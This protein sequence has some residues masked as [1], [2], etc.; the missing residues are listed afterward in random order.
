MKNFLENLGLFV[1]CLSVMA[2]FY[3][4]LHLVPIGNEM[5]I[6]YKNK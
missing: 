6:E 5:I 1:M 4:L 3:I 2:I